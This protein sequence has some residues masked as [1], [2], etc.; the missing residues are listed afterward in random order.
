MNRPTWHVVARGVRRLEVFEKAED[1]RSFLD[2]LSRAVERYACELHAYAL[3]PNHYHLL[4]TGEPDAVGKCLH[5]T[6]RPYS[7]RH[8]QENDLRGRSF[9]S[10]YRRFLQRTPFWM[11][12]TSLYIHQNPVAARLAKSSDQYPWSSCAA[13]LGKSP[14]IPGL[15]VGSLLRVINPNPKDARN[16]YRAL[17]DSYAA[18]APA[19]GAPT[20]AQVW[21]HQAHALHSAVREH[22][23][24]LPRVNPDV[25]AVCLGR[26]AGIPMHILAHACGLH[27]PNT[28]HV[29]S[30]RLRQR[31]RDRDLA[32]R[33]RE[34]TDAMGLEF[35]TSARRAPGV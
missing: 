9:D 19:A 31:F 13:Y 17:L 10:P 12:R 8:N 5:A 16:E 24:A 7:R 29:L 20:A 30:Y 35:P 4:L 25:L 22:G 34:W 28:A 26:H 27:D 2:L 15:S 1:Y 33:L 18:T 32:N 11:V 23:P 6:N 3:L 21:T 14:G